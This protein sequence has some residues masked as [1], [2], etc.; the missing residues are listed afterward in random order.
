MTDE[1]RLEALRVLCRVGVTDAERAQSQ[2]LE[3]DLVLE[4]DLGAAGAS[5]DVDDTV[6]Y[7]EVALV[8]AAAVESTH[9]HLVERVATVAADAA[10]RVAGRGAAVTVTVRK[11]RPPIPLDVR[12]AGVRLRR[13]S[14]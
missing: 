8:V 9:H 14:S 2:P 10:L 3:I 6:D 4:L 7:G 11:L 1:I 5:D 12:T 13:T